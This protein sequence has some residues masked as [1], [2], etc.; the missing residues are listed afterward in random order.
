VAQ[1][2][3][4]TCF[5]GIIPKN[6]PPKN[7]K[8]FSKDP[9]L[10]DSKLKNEW[11]SPTDEWS[12]KFAQAMVDALNAGVA[13]EEADRKAGIKPTRLPDAPPKPR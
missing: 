13:K 2:L 5:R 10:Q 9:N 12:L 1:E 3:S 4:E 8:I 7:S 6:N 11:P